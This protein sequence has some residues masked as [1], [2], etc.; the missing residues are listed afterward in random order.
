MLGSSSQRRFCSYF[1]KR[2]QNQQMNGNFIFQKMHRLKQ[3]LAWVWSENIKTLKL[4]LLVKRSEK[5]TGKTHILVSNFFVCW[6]MYVRM[7]LW[8]S[9]FVG[10][11]H[12]N[13]DLEC[14]CWKNG[15]IFFKISMVLKHIE[16]VGFNAARS[17]PIW[18]NY[19]AIPGAK[20]TKTVWLILGKR[21]IFE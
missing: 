15:R 6:K 2:K 16:C 10:S 19:L 18:T 4:Q 9:I 1:K 17:G 7:Y 12:R 20:C 21:A 8:I 14:A 11:E 5:I 3:S 13:L